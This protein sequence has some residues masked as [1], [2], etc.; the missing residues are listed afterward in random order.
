MRQVHAQ[1]RPA[2]RQRHEEDQDMGFYD[3]FV[4]RAREAREAQ[5]QDGE[6]EDDT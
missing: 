6:D 4:R 5:E 3:P 1:R 2:R